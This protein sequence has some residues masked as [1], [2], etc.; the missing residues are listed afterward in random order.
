LVEHRRKLVDEKTRLSNRLTAALKSYYPQPLQW[1]DDIDAPLGCAFLQRWPTLAQAQHSHPGTLRKFFVQHNC[2]SAERIRERIEGIHQATPAVT[3]TALLEAG[4][5][6]VSGIVRASQALSE[7]IAAVDARLQ[8]AVTEHPQAGI[9]AGLPGA[10]AVL[11]PRL[12]AAFGTQ[13]D[14]FPS[15]SKL[16]CHTGIAPVHSQTGNT[17][18]VH[19]RRACPKFLR[20]TFVEFASHSVAKSVWAR[21]FL[22]NQ[23]AQQKDYNVAIRA[24]AFKWQRIL[25]ACWRNNTPYDEQRYLQTLQKRNSPLAKL[26]AIPKSAPTDPTAVGW[27]SVAGFHTLAMKNT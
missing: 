16:Q 25:H 6:I 9:F 22:Q 12:I 5:I 14:R 20:Q 1:F 3:D 11:L 19:M 10:G 15:A 7:S 24:L 26:S 2:R 18:I 17:E 8:S 21:A 27:K 13:L 4:G 23:L